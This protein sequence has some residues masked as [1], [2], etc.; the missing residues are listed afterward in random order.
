MRGRQG[1]AIRVGGNGEV[2]IGGGYAGMPWTL[3]PEPSMMPW[4]EALA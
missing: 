4:H 1:P 2:S 3:G